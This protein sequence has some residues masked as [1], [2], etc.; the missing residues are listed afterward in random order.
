MSTYLKSS[1][2]SSAKLISALRNEFLD[3]SK[4]IFNKGHDLDTYISFM[5]DKLRK[6]G[7]VRTQIEAGCMTNLLILCAMYLEKEEEC[8]RLKKAVDLLSEPDDAHS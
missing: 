1:S 5:M 4:E 6:S 3:Q 8:E 7:L 2:E